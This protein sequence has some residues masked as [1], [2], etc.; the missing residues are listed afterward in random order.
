VLTHCE[1]VNSGCE[2][3]NSGCEGVNSGSENFNATE[4]IQM[5]LMAGFNVISPASVNTIWLTNIP[6]AHLHWHKHP[7][8]YFKGNLYYCGI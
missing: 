7:Y 6:T 8:K 4:L 1:G 2:D 3:V 5:V